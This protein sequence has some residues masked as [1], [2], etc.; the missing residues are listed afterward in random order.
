MHKDYSC[1]LFPYE[2]EDFLSIQEVK[3]E[4]AWSITAFNLPDAWNLT[5][6]EG[7]KI[8]ILDTG[9]DL[10]HPD[11]VENLLEGKNFVDPN[12]PP[13][14]DNGHGCVSPDCLVHTS[15]SGIEEI[16]SLYGKIE[17]QENIYG[18]N[19]GDYCVKNVSDIDIRTY[20]FDTDSQISVEGKI[21][22][23]QKLPING[24]V[25]RVTLEGGE[26]YLLTP[27][28]PVY[29]TKNR[30]H[31]V[32]E[33]QR[34]RADEIGV[35]DH[36]IFGRGEFAG[37]LNE[38]NPSV[39]LPPVYV[40]ERCEHVPRWWNGLMPGRCKK[41][42]GTRWTSVSKEIVIDNDL[43]YLVG[44][45]LTDGHVSV[46]LNR[47]EITST[48]PELL[49]EVDRIATQRGWTTK[50]EEK[51]ILVY[52]FNAVK[53]MIALGILSGNK[54]LIQTLPEWVSLATYECLTSFIAGVIDG[55]GCISITNTKNRITTGN[56]QFAK[57][58]AVLLNSMG[59]SASVSG[60]HFSS[61]KEN[62]NLL[63]SASGKRK[64]ESKNPVYHIVHTA[65]SKKI[66]EKLIHPKRALR[67]TI[68][69]KYQ[70][71]SRRVKSIN[72]EDFKGFFYDFTVEK[73]HNYI[74]NGHFVSN[75][76]LAGTIVACNNEIG[77]VGVA[78]KAKVV[79]VKVLDGQ[80]NGNLLQV[81]TGIRWA[82]EQKV[83]FISLS[84]GAPVP[85]QQVRKAIQ[86]AAEAGIV[87]FCAAGNAGET[88]DIFYPA[89]Y[90]ETIAIG[91]IDPSMRRAV[92]S[93]TGKNLDFMAPGVDVL[94][95]VPDSWYA[96]MSGTSMAT[97]FAC[98]VAALVLSYVRSHPSCGIILR[99]AQDYIDLFKQYTIP[100]ENGNYSDPHF[101][102]GFGII[103]P[104]KF[105][106]A[107]R[108]LH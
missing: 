16:E 2:R 38:S 46:P 103:D 102:Q 50:L 49:I 96:K 64:I 78:P 31:D 88:K 40:C 92:F 13:A 60:P 22:S 54:S 6:G 101:Y 47:F 42:S 67:S 29:L 108:Q 95:T 61:K 12:L 76:H 68:Q 18:K 30:H 90:P 66:A 53:T 33:I 26:E 27:W 9:I 1:S 59:I 35:G 34:K 74:A 80:G 62:I 73:Y 52:G 32:Y 14:D 79:P 70:R 58:M 91:A 56:F 82:I 63:L 93:N 28:H 75:T 94:S 55:D 3:Q 15:Y 8:A 69:P 72:V 11:L 89:A 97:P 44:L 81:A 19:E 17:V 39:C 84:L 65:L 7:V 98:G 71:K 100:V 86:A 87:T 85:V 99:T 77:V 24:E 36:F 57:H 5:Q 41:C 25:V 37:H 51:R 83:D 21:T 23:I 4:A 106:A 48:T 105:M 43:A 20:S 104:K 10:L 45:C 107:M